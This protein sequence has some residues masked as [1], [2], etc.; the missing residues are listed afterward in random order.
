MNDYL[1]IESVLSGTEPAEK[2]NALERNFCA[3]YKLNF[4]IG[5]MAG[6]LA[7]GYFAHKALIDMA[8]DPRADALVAAV[9][10]VSRKDGTKHT[11][12]MRH[13]LDYGRTEIV[14]DVQRVWLIGS[15]I[16]LGDKF[17]EATPRYLSRSP[18]LELVYH[19][20]NAAAHGSKFH[21]LDFGIERLKRYEAHNKEA[22]VKSAVF[23]VTPNLDK[24]GL[25]D[26]IGPGDVL[27]VLQ[28]V[29]VYLTRIRERRQSGELSDDGVLAVRPPH[30]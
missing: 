5:R 6:R 30:P 18:L 7:Q 1:L 4:E 25:F 26:F 19:L 16:A 20:R 21:F 3:K 12:D 17:D 10:D 24:M 23:E 14:D 22:Q 2:L 29:E 9:G 11:F 13:Y 28:S 8:T 15:L 27:D